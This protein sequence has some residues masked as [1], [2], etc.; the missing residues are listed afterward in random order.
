MA[1]DC[2]LHGTTITRFVHT[3]V[4]HDTEAA[5]VSESSCPIDP[6]V[7]ATEREQI[8]AAGREGEVVKRIARGCSI[9]QDIVY[10]SPSLTF[11]FFLP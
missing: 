8:Y 6:V 11:S 5:K 2:L 4:H 1:L 9:E 3:A 7:L 10:G